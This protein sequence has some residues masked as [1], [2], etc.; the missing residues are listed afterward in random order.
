[1]LAPGHILPDFAEP[2]GPTQPQIAA[3]CY[4]QLG[5]LRKNSLSQHPSDGLKRL[6]VILPRCVRSADLLLDRLPDL[7]MLERFL[8]DWIEADLPPTRQEAA[9]FA[10]L[11]RHIRSGEFHVIVR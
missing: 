5:K 8:Y 4:F 7:R 10:Q 3:P 1:M 2:G 6:V 9:I 11:L